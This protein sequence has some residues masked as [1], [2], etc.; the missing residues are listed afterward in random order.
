MTYVSIGASAAGKRIHE[1][2][3]RYQD[4][5]A[6]KA[7]Y[8]ARKK[9]VQAALDARAKKRAAKAREA[10]I[11]AKRKEVA[12]QTR[13]P[14]H[15]IIAEVAAAHNLTPADITGQRRAR[16]LSMPRQEAMYRAMMETNLTYPAV[17]LIF[18]RDHTTILHGVRVHASRNNLP[19]VP[20]QPPDRK[21]KKRN[22][23]T[24]LPKET[25]NG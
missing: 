5:L 2:G 8:E 12:E 6:A 17:G 23:Y 21:G 20:G 9:A 18:K 25:T 24:V 3:K 15:R 16:V 10:E 13:G 22:S 7:S 11:A 14:V 19:P 4:Y 1:A